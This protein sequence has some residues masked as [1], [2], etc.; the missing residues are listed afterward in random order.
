MI[1]VLLTSSLLILILALLRRVLRGR[2]SLRLQYALWVLVAVRLLV[3]V[4]FGSSSVS[5]L[6]AV[7]PVQHQMQAVWSADHTPG[8]YGPAGDTGL[9]RAVSGDGFPAAH[10][11]RRRLAVRRDCHGPVVP[12]G[13]LDLPP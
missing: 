8:R 3:P 4:S 10:G 2:V 7:E 5:V 13:Q 6:N 1:Q 11:T 12:G 9:R